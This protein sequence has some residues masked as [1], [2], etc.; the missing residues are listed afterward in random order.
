MKDERGLTVVEILV[1]LAI[2]AVITVGAL[3]VIGATN[4]GGLLE[5]IPT[6]TITGRVAK[7]YTVASVYLQ[8]FQEYMADYVDGATITLVLGTNTFTPSAADVFGFPPPSSQP[9]Q[10]TW[11]QLVVTAQNWYWDCATQAYDPAVAATEDHLVMVRSTLT[12]RLKGEDR[13][14]TVQRFVPYRPDI[15]PS[16]TPCP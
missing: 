15:P 7:D 10:L 4:S 1:A 8:A 2:F 5:G 14:V 9:Y 6:G 12:W 13:T 11:E 16:V 3:G